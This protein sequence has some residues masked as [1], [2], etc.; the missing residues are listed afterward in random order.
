M[1]LN[2]PSQAVTSH[3]KDVAD[4]TTRDAY[5]FVINAARR[6]EQNI[7]LC[8]DDPQHTPQEF[9]NEF[10]TSAAASMNLNRQLIELVVAYEQATDQTI[11][12]RAIIAKVGS[13][14]VNSDGTVTITAE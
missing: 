2:P 6:A 9:I 11:L 13:F 4:Q 8:W 3:A 1:S 5:D 7:N 14:S 10:G 12:D